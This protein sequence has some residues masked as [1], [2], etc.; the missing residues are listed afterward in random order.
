[1]PAVTRIFIKNKNFLFIIIC[2][3]VSVTVLPAQESPWFWYEGFFAEVSTPLH[4]PPALLKD[5]LEPGFGFRGALGYEYQRFRFAIEFGYSHFAGKDSLISQIDISP[6]V[7]KFGYGLPLSSI[8]KL[9]FDLPI[10]L[11]ADVSTGFAFSNT[12]Y[13]KTEMDRAM[14]NIQV[15]PVNSSFMLGGRLYA[16]VTPLNFLRIFAGGGV[17]LI[18]ENEGPLVMPVIEIGV[19]FKP[20]APAAEKERQRVLALARAEEE[21]QRLLAEEQARAE[22]ERQWL[23]AE[24]QKRLLAEER[25]RLLAE[26]RQRLLALAQAEEER[27]RL[28]ALAQAEEEHQRLL[29]LALAEEERQRLALERAE[30]LARAIELAQHS[31]WFLPESAIL[32]ESEKLRL[33]ELATILRNIPGIKIQVEGHT[34]L[35][36]T[37]E[38][39]YELSRQRAQA[40]A[41]YLILLEA[42][43]DSDVTVIGHGAE[44]PLAYNNLVSGMAANRRVEII[45]LEK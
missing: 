35:A 36:G 13:Y 26:E 5:Y 41:S 20:F 17:D 33:G 8:F 15:D 21:R 34:A 16:T 9:P 11:Q 37:V 32:L 28:F 3:L 19:H 7:F 25:Q 30:E 24:E 40:V 1:M 14:N 6:L 29:A 12:T 4:F 42:L 43:N 31:I 39:C 23:L 2:L 22:E 27:Q 45:I 44:R 18:L 10:G 38:S